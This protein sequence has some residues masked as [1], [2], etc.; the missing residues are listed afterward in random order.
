MGFYRIEKDRIVITVRAIPK[1]GS[2]RIE[3]VKDGKLRVRLRAAPEDGKANKELVGLIAKTLGVRKDQVEILRGESSR[4][5]SVAV[6]A[7]RAEGVMA[8]EQDSDGPQ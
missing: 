8:W 4:D 7:E 3:G 6:P 5:K 2:S 1:G